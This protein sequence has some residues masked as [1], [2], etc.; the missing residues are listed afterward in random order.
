MKNPDAR[1]GTG[2]L[3]GYLS[4]KEAA[5]FADVPIGLNRPLTLYEEADMLAA[6][7]CR[8]KIA[9]MTPEALRDLADLTVDQSEIFLGS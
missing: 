3:P 5:K 1:P 8:E 6:G 4:P 2:T 9:D 7:L